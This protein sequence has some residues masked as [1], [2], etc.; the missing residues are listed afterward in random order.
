MH[1]MTILGSPRLAGNTAQVLGCFERLI[2]AEHA[3]ERVNLI[4]QRI[5]GCLG[6]EACQTGLP[7]P[8]CVQQDDGPQ[9]LKRIVDADFVVYAT[10]LYA[11]GFSAQMKALIDRHYCLVHAQDPSRHTSLLEAKP[12]ALLV[13]CSGPDAG[14]ADLLRETFM[15]IA[16]YSQMRVIGIYV[17]PACTTPDALGPAADKIAQEMRRDFDERVALQ[18]G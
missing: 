16:A 14:N 10:P 5:G 2:A 6:C 11:W 15:R 9:V 18:D 7:Q 17:L 12:A 1:V 8:D 4:A 13:T 3:V